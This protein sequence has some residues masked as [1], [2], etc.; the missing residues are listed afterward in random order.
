MKYLVIENKEHSG[1]RLLNDVAD[2]LWNNGNE[3]LTRSST[4]K[5]NLAEDYDC[6]VLLM[7]GNFRATSFFEKNKG[8]LH[9]KYGLRESD[10]NRSILVLSDTGVYSNAI[11]FPHKIYHFDTLDYD[12]LLGFFNWTRKLNLFSHSQRI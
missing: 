7:A 3:V 6:I 9:E 11:P 12:A 5:E 4:H 1:N 2:F 8:A 10:G